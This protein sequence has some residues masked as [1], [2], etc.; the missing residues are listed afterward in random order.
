VQE[1]FPIFLMIVVAVW[2]VTRVLRGPRPARGEQRL[3][4]ACGA[5]H[6]GFARFCRRLGR[7]FVMKIDVPLWQQRLF[8]RTSRVM[9]QVSMGKTK[10]GGRCR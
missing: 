5:N 3:C 1:M 6:P 8:V 9:G 7:Q 10:D 4:R 2:M